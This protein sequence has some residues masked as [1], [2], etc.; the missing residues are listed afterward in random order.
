MPIPESE[1]SFALGHKGSI[2][3]KLAVASS[4]IIEYVGDVAY[5]AGT[6]VERTRGRDYLRWVLLQL[7]GEVAVPNYQLRLDIAAVPL[8]NRMAGY[9]NGNKGRLLRATE[10]LTGTFCFVGKSTGGDSKPLIICG[11]EQ[12]KEAAFFALDKYLADHQTSTWTDEGKSEETNSTEALKAQLEAIVKPS[13]LLKKAKDPWKVAST[14]S[15]SYKW[16][17]QPCPGAARKSAEL[18]SSTDKSTVLL[19]QQVK[20][21]RQLQ[22]RSSEFVNDTMAFPELGG[23]KRVGAP[24]PDVVVVQKPAE[25]PVVVAEVMPPSPPPPPRSESE[26]AGIFIDRVK[27]EVW[28]DWGLGP[29][30]DPEVVRGTA[31]PTAQAA[32]L[33]GAWK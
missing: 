11:T 18:L 10:E 4:C 5:F 28:G 16:L 22:Q 12:A 6:L 8:R 17:C 29:R 33:M 7:E 19:K 21:E 14:E 26:N 9:V 2:R 1:L 31:A 20:K 3:K 27:G 30:G 24:V 32:K 13:G 25:V 15:V 23:S